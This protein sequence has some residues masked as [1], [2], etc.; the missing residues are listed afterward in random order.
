MLKLE[1]GSENHRAGPGLSGPS[2]ADERRMRRWPRRK[3]V[4]N[5]ENF[6]NNSVCHQEELRRNVGKSGIFCIPWCLPCPPPTRHHCPKLQGGDKQVK[7]KENNLHFFKDLKVIVDFQKHSSCRVSYCFIFN[8]W[9]LSSQ[10]PGLHR[11]L[12]WRSPGSPGN[13]FHHHITWSIST[14]LTSSPWGSWKRMFWRSALGI[15]NCWKE[16]LTHLDQKRLT[17]LKNCTIYLGF[18]FAVQRRKDKGQKRTFV[19]LFLCASQFESFLSF[20][21]WVINIFII[22]VLIDLGEKCF[23]EV[24]SNDWSPSD[25]G[26]GRSLVLTPWKLLPPSLQDWLPCVPRIHLPRSPLCLLHPS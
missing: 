6:R 25:K 21:L 10:M 2:G 4:L 11:K 23:W 7:I 24:K 1:G 22:P 20:T 14:T 26:W 16:N 13:I 19:G 18:L 5:K 15:R 17:F 3:R 8:L 9:D 12:M